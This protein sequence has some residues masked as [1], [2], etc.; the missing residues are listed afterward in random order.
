LS[1]NVVGSGTAQF[2]I[3]NHGITGDECRIYWDNYHHGQWTADRAAVSPQICTT[4]SPKN[5]IISAYFTRQRFIFVEALP[6]TERFNST[7]FT[8]K[9]LLNIV[10]SVSIFRP[11][12]RAQ[13][14]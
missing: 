3:K 11:K 9:V 4:I 8:E 7:F 2:T 6:E 12:M 5:T 10:R 13:C 1:R 14:Y